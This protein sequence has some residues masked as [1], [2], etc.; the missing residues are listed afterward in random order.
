[1]KIVSRYIL[2]EHVGPFLF[3]IGLLTLIFLLN[4]VWRDLGRLLS[5]GLDA[6]TIFEFLYL[7]LAWMIAL[8][9]PMSVL[10]ATLMTFGRLSADNEI[11]ALKASGVSFYQLLFPVLLA[12]AVITVL[13]IIYNDTVL[14]EFNHRTR[15]LRDDI[16]RKRPTL[17]LEPNVVF[18]DIPNMNLITKKVIER[19]DSSR[20]ETVVID[21]RSDENVR[22]TIFAQWGILKFDKAADRMFLDLY[23]GEIHELDVEDYAKYRRLEFEHYR[24][25]VEI[26]GLSLKRSESNIRGD[27][28]MTI[29]M[30]KEQIRQ[31]REAI[32]KRR[33]N[34]RRLVERQLTEA[35]DPRLIAKAASLDTLPAVA[36]PDSVQISRG[37]AAMLDRR[38]KSFE[39]QLKMEQRIIRSHER[40][41]DSYWVEIHK[42]YSIPVACI[43][44]VLVGAPLGVLS[45]KGNLGVSA[46]IS[47]I[48]YLVH[49][50]F[51]IQG[52]TLADRQIIS[53]AVAM[54]GADIIVGLIGLYLVLF[55]V[56]EYRPIQWHK[57]RL[58][59]SRNP[60]FYEQT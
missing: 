27:R 1:M 53:P 21:D 36:N 48:F 13:M 8:A 28:E 46:G 56:R 2:K 42:K 23:N 12:S 20:L 59:L 47:I 37:V 7:N 18:T 33:D 26:P 19:G 50:V 43:I 39:T 9:V 34:L 55:T 6:G 15:L 58:R 31:N 54:W 11:T 32:E 57:L 22:R 10:I 51:L 17:R 30:M 35:F 38:L 40:K 4:L 3:G 14:P 29:A 44:F 52:E 45:R 41:I 60:A 49:W 25:N 24:I 16:V 5:R